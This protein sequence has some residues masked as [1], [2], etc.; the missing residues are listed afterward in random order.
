MKW[1]QTSL[2]DQASGPY[3]SEAITSQKNSVHRCRRLRDGDGFVRLLEQL[4][5]RENALRTW[6]TAAGRF[7]F[8]KQLV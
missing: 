5:D 2:S 1:S 8:K 6:L 4:P 7:F 3:S